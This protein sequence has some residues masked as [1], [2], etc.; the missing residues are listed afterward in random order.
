MRITLAFAALTVLLSLGACGKSDEKSP[1]PPEK[2]APESGVT[3][4]ADQVRGLGIATVAAKPADYRAEASGYGTVVSLDTIAQADSDL[5]SAEAVA[6]QS[7]AAATRARYLF[8]DQGGAVSRESM[9]AAVARAQ[10]DEAQLALARRKAQAAFGLAPPWEKSG[11]HGAI[12][13]RLSSGA[14]VMVRVSFPIGALPETL[15]ESLSIA[16]LGG[17]ARWTTKQL[18]RAPADPA[19]PGQGIFALVAGSDL[20]QNEHVNAFVPAGTAQPGVSVPAAAIVYG[21]GESWVYVRKAADNF[22][23]VPVDTSRRLAD[24]YFVP[25]DGG[26]APGDAVVTTGAG[27]LLAR[28]LNPSTEAED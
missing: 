6:A 22:Q 21:E 11:Q 23:R 13:G 12:M 2:E 25:Q 9:E 27:L 8:S 10:S 3:L 1:A 5:M 28:E 26:I 16:R 20:T 17:T 4:S 18:W 15:P 7:R 19:F 24:G 14:L